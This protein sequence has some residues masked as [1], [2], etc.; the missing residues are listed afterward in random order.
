MILLV[1]VSHRRCAGNSNNESLSGKELS[2]VKGTWESESGCVSE[3]KASRGVG[4][5]GQIHL[6]QN[7]FPN[8]ANNY[9]FSELEVSNLDSGT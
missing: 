2:P 1:K 9:L 8:F 6:Y 7:L 4:R 3:P 5:L